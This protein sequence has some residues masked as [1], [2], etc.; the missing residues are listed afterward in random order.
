ME[1]HSEPA[2]PARRWEQFHALGPGALGGCRAQPV[3]RAAGK[4]VELLRV[5]TASLH[6]VPR[7]LELVLPH[8]QLERRDLL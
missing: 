1:V 4:D 6:Q 8:R 5:H 7:D 2:Q 3:L